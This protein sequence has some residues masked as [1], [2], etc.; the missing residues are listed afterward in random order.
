MGAF[1]NKAVVVT[2]GAHGI[3]KAVAEEFRIA[4]ARA[5][6][7]RSVRRE[8]FG[9]SRAYFSV[10]DIS[11]VIRYSGKGR[12]AATDEYSVTGTALLGT[13][14]NA[15]VIR[16]ARRGKTFAK[17]IKRV[18]IPHDNSGAMEKGA[19]RGKEK[20]DAQS[21]LSQFLRGC[22]IWKANK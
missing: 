12:K 22:F 17:D 19:Q 13:A 5:D 20:P 1:Q 7:E 11:R 9:D 14:G 6:G 10:D 16:V 15:G 4:L 21:R 8:R 3:G 18:E 2:G